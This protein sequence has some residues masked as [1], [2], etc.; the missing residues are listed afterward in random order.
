MGRLAALAVATSLASSL[1]VDA[2]AAD[3]APPGGSGV[4]WEI[5][6]ELT[7]I[8]QGA[9]GLPV[10]QKQARTDRQCFP[11]KVPDRLPPQH[12]FCKLSKFKRKGPRVTFA[13]S[14]PQ[15]ITGKAELRWTADTY[16]GTMIMRDQGVENRI[17]LTGKKVG[18]DCDP[19]ATRREQDAAAQAGG[20]A[21][22]DAATKQRAQE[23]LQGR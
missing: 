13:L 3:A 16:A 19:T 6:S 8:L 5:T 17:T 11:K 2:Q 15:G 18:G 22:E 14:C 7:L 12:G 23:A 4:W 21:Q 9:S 20:D 1:Y 10:A